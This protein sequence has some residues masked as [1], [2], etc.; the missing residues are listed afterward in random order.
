LYETCNLFSVAA[1]AKGL[2]LEFHWHGA[3]QQRYL[4]DALRLR[5]V[6][7]N[8]VGNAIKFTAAGSVHVTAT[9]VKRDGDTALL[10]F[11]VTDTGIGIA[12][13]KMHLLFKPFSQADSSTTRRFGGSGLGLSIVSNLA[14][15][16]G[17]EA[18]VESVVDKGSRFWFRVTSELLPQGSHPQ[19]SEARHASVSVGVQPP[20]HVVAL[21]GRVLVAE[22]DLVNFQVILA[23]LNQLGLQA[24]LAQNGQ[25]AVDTLMRCEADSF[26]DLILMDLHMPGMDGYAATQQIRQWEAAKQRPHLPI[27]ALTADAFEEVRLHCLAVGMD[28]VLTKPIELDGFAATL[29]R[30]LPS[31]SVTEAVTDTTVSIKPFDS[32]QLTLL[33]NELTPLLE[34][35][36]FDAMRRFKTL[37]TLLSGTHLEP[38]VDQ[39]EHLL[40]ELRF[41]LVL[42][43]LRGLSGHLINKESSLLAAVPMRVNLAEFEADV[44]KTKGPIGPFAFTE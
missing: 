9:E 11:A 19:H 26:P 29:A 16:M 12:A 23:F 39:M 10:E 25:Q 22:D 35:N 20:L 43:H 21:R 41:D 38:D 3:P 44:G 17:G 13:D 6:L 2:T 1:K 15:A 32:D 14:R 31:G 4:A 34:R 28:D 40:K 42:A 37:K 33:I 27:I 18:G 30:W 24:T 7:S 5:Q 8:L 36:S